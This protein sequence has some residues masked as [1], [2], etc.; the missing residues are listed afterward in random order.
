MRRPLPAARL[1]GGE[2]WVGENEEENEAHPWV[3]LVREE[4]AG[5]G[6]SA[7]DSEAAAQALVGGGVPVRWKWR[8]V[9]GELHLDMRELLVGSI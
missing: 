2:G 7:E 6:G 1:A 4:V 3:P 8:G 9:A 5:G